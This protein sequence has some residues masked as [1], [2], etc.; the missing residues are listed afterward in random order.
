MTV[1]V[2]RLSVLATP[3]IRAAADAVCRH[4]QWEV[5]VEM[6]RRNSDDNEDGGGPTGEDKFH[7]DMYHLVFTR[8]KLLTTQSHNKNTLMK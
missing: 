5:V 6:A 4:L 3:R 1:C 2:T 7:L 8:S